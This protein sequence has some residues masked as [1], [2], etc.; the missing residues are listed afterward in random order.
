MQPRTITISLISVF[1]LSILWLSSC[2]D[3]DLLEEMDDN[4]QISIALSG[5]DGDA[6]NDLEVGYTS[7]C[8]GDVTTD[9]PEPG[10]AGISGTVTILSAQYA[11]FLQIEEYR[12]EYIPQ[13]SPLWGG[14]TDFPPF[15]DEPEDLEITATVM[16]GEEISFPIHN[17]LTIDNKLNYVDQGGLLTFA[18]G[19]YVIRITFFGLENEK[20]IELSLDTVVR[21]MDIDNCD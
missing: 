20:E 4:Y 17:V 3:M 1:L 5:G 18:Q 21:L 8:D 2:G 14:G 12:L 15:L 10:L 9:D 11:P 7:D 6:P 19:I 16:P 13:E